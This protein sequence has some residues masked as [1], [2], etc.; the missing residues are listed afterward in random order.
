MF[1]LPAV[2][3]VPAGLPPRAHPGPRGGAGPDRKLKKSRTKAVLA[4]AGAGG[5]ADFPPHAIA[6]PD[7]RVRAP[8]GNPAAVPGR[9][10]TRPPGEPAIPGPAA[11]RD[12]SRATGVPRRAAGE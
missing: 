8:A 5:M 4:L 2:R 3:A 10:V 12:P 1:A 9:R 6:A 11:S 7:R